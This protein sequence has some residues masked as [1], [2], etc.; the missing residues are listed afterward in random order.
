MDKIAA[1][2]AQFPECDRMMAETILK[3]HEQGRLAQYLPDLGASPEEDVVPGTIHVAENIS[4]LP[5]IGCADNS[6]D[7]SS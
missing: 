1:L 6:V 2:Q 3:L 4:D 7:S 5:T